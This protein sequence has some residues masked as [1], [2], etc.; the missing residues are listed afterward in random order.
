[1]SQTLYRFGIDASNS[2][3]KTTIPTR[4]HTAACI[5]ILWASWCDLVYTIT[6]DSNT[7]TI[8]YTG[9]SLTATQQ[10]EFTSPTSKINLALSRPECRLSFFG[11]AMHDGVRGYICDDKI[12]I[13]GTPAEQAELGDQYRGIATW[14]LPSPVAEVVMCSDSS[15]ILAHK[16]G[17]DDTESITTF[18]SFQALKDYCSKAADAEFE[19]LATFTPTQLVTNA[20]TATAL[21]PNGHVYTRTTDPRYP[22]TLGRPPTNSSVFEPVLYLSEL[23]IAK[24]ASGG[25]MTAAISSEGE[26]FLWGQA[27]PGTKGELGVLHKL[28]YNQKPNPKDTV[29][30]GDTEQDEYVRCLNVFINGVE[31]AVEDVAIGTGHILITARNGR[32]E[33]VLFTAGC[34]SEGQL[35]I[36]RTV[37]FVSEFE[38]VAALRGK[39]VIQMA[40]AGWSS[41]VVAEEDLNSV[42]SCSN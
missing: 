6:D 38:E 32:S 34:G 30:W 4:I 12:T 25:Y 14:T 41:F 8:I 37:E 13:F 23:T 10:S 17:P 16:Q 11:S 1:M 15:L 33:R 7:R 2:F 39:R 18:L 9:T 29:I 24:I 22:F 26:L 42:G 5:T 36:G 21:S 31:A 28:D 40:A 20:T 27:N 35:G 19:R 3:I